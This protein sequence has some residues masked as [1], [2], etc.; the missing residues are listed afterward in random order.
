MMAS[1]T[2]VMPTGLPGRRRYA[3]QQQQQCDRADR[4]HQRVD[5]AELPCQ[6]DGPVEEIVAAAGDTKQARQLAHDD[7]ESRSCLEPDQDAVADEAHEHAELEQPGDEAQHRY[8]EGRETCDLRITRR[9]TAGERPDGRSDHQG[10]GRGRADRKLSR[11]S[12]QGIADTAEHVAI[13]TNLRWQTGQRR[14]GE[15]NRDSVGGERDARDGVGG[16]PFTPIGRKPAS[17]RKETLPFGLGRR[18][19]RA[20]S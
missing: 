6:L 15:R 10:D 3:D 7:G 4:Q 5:L 17:R 12:Q 1:A 8:G 13:D 9:I 2:T 18:T 19:H 20:A 11:R 14:I 16:E